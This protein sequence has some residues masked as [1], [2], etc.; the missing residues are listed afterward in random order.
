MKELIGMKKTNKLKL[1]SIE[2]HLRTTLFIRQ[3]E[4]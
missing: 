1:I 3:N 2:K 4:N